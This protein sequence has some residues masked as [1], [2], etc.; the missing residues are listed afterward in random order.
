M[1]EIYFDNAATTVVSPAAAGTVLR[2]MTE[3]YGNPSSLHEKG[4]AAEGYVRAAAKTIAGTMKVSPNE[5]YFTSGGTEANNWALF[6]AARANARLGK[7]ILTS[8][9]EHPAVAEVLKNLAGDGFEVIAV[10]VDSQGR[11]DLAF[12]EKELTPEVILASFMM[13]NNEIGTVEPVRAV[14]EAVHA[15]RP[16]ALFHVDAVQGFGK[17]QI[18][19]KK[20]GVDLL[21]VSGHKIHAPKGIGFLYIADKV[22]VKN[23]IFGG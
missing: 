5:I 15:E 6:G 7:K 17:A 1:R 19:P 10:P 4:V 16:E 14:G 9:M 2:V 11:L 8:A 18:Y 12:F 22:K 13:V 3:D 20:W 23:L 21:S